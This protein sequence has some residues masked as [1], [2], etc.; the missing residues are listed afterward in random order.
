MAKKRDERRVLTLLVLV[1]ALLWALFGFFWSL[2]LV[3]TFLILAY[4][5]GREEVASDV[6]RGKR[7]VQAYDES[8]DDQEKE[9]YQQTLNVPFTAIR[10]ARNAGFTAKSPDPLLS[11]VTRT[12]NLSR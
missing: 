3:F 10:S 6:A 7:E 9:F 1:I 4:T 5:F 8:F 11:Q 12:L 2:L